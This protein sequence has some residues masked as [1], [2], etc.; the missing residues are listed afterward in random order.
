MDSIRRRLFRSYADLGATAFL[1]LIIPV[2][3]WFEL[4]VVLPSIRF[5]HTP[6]LYY[7]HLILGSVLMFQIV[8]KKSGLNRFKSRN[9]LSTCTLCPCLSLLPPFAGNWV[10]VM[11]TNTS[12][13]GVL[14]PIPEKSEIDLGSRDKWRFCATCEALQPPRTWH[15]KTC[16]QCILK[17]DHHCLFTGCCIGHRNQRYFLLLVGYLFIATTYCTFYNNYFIW[18]LH[19]KEFRNGWTLLKMIF[20]FAWFMIDWSMT[21]FYF[22]VYMINLVGSLFTGALLYYHLKNALA[23]DLAFEATLKKSEKTSYDQGWLKNLQMVFGRSWWVAIV[24]PFARSALPHDGVHWETV[25]RNKT[26]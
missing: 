18:I 1:G 2:T 26:H 4:S 25:A 17:R 12:T 20:P 21:Q 3:Y 13:K 11:L 7:G 5:L 23:G 8:G 6:L 15:C 9:S 10:F 14:M 22:M 24:N 16:N 19:A